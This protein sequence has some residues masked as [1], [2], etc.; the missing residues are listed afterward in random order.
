MKEQQK[1]KQINFIKPFTYVCVILP[2]IKEGWTYMYNPVIEMEF[3]I[4]NN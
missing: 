2:C 3:L 4:C 1:S